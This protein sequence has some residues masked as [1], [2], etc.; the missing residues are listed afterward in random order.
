MRNE[1]VHSTLLALVGGYVLFLAWQILENYRNGAGEM[2]DFLYILI[3]V[4]MALGGLGAIFYAWTVYRKAIRS[5][6]NAQ[7]E[8]CRPDETAAPTDDNT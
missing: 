1:K 5:E 6:K 8:A 4:L 7:D 3:I 2:S